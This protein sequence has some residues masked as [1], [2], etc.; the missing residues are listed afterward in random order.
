MADIV[1]LYTHSQRSQEELPRLAAR[2]GELWDHGA[3]EKKLGSEDV[4]SMV[5][6]EGKS[7]FAK[8]V[9]KIG[10]LSERRTPVERVFSP[11]IT[12]RFVEREG[13]KSSAGVILRIKDEMFGVMFVNYRLPQ[14]FTEDRRAE[15]KMFATQ[16]AIAIQRARNVAEAQALRE[17]GKAVA[18][19]RFD[20]KQILDLILERAYELIGFSTGWISLVNDQADVLEI[21]AARGLKRHE[22]RGVPKGQGIVWD[23]VETGEYRNEDDI[24]DAE[25][26]LEF[27][28]D[29]ASE[30][31]VPL[32]HADEVLGVFNVE[33]TRLAAF[34]RR[35]EEI[36]LAL[37]NEASTAVAADK[38]LKQR[39]AVIEDL[40]ALNRISNG[41]G[42]QDPLN[43]RQISRLLHREKGS[44]IWTTSTWHRTALM[45][46]WNSSLLFKTATS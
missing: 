26:Y 37:A 31:C 5:V 3:M 35:D 19:A 24:R 20:L 44:W 30:L 7:Y 46:G 29:T 1:T 33:S 11:D 41:L 14:D 15:I 13:I 34:K 39:Q 21:R 9:T 25:D 32:V 17:V 10:M 42:T 43:I 22:W 6:K 8:D 40:K 38:L 27:S 23:V 12:K 28:N 45:D 16:A 2:A 18:R 4:P 36:V